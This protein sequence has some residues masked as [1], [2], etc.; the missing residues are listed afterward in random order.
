MKKCKNKS[1]ITMAIFLTIILLMV[2]GYCWS[3]F[4]Y[5]QLNNSQRLCNS[6]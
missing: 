6:H 4:Y 1:I 5:K 3:D 2:G